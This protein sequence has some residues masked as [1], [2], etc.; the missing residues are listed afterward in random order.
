MGYREGLV[1]PCR[2]V[3]HYHH[4]PRCLPRSKST[5]VG[6]GPQRRDTVRTLIN[7]PCARALKLPLLVRSGVFFLFSL[8]S[9]GTDF[10][11]VCRPL[12]RGGNFGLPST[13]PVFLYSSSYS[14]ANGITP[15]HRSREQGGTQSGGSECLHREHESSLLSVVSQVS[16]SLSL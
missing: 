1:F 5:N 9:R 15:A 14:R 4:P 11:C 6:N 8:L 12:S 13:R 10:W 7:G 3:T 2:N 16:D